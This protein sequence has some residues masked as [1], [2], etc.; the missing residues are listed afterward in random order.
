MKKCPF[1]AEEIQDAAI[2]CKHCGERLDQAA[3]QPEDPVSF[4]QKVMPTDSAASLSAQPYRRSFGI[5]AFLF[6]GL[7]VPVFWLSGALGAV[8]GCAIHPVLGFVIL[9]PLFAG[10]TIW[11]A[12]NL[13]MGYVGACPYCQNGVSTGP[14][15]FDC[16]VCKGRVVVDRASR[17]F[18]AASTLVGDACP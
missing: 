3:A 4:I 16:P 8:L 11:I 17:T 2:K 14:G 6:L 10:T 5:T 15:V 7:S 13:G 18:V 12:L 1:C 9:G